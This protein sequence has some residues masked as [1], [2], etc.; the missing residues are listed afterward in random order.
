[1]KFELFDL[2]LFINVAEQS[3]L[4]KGAQRSCISLPAASAR[5]KHLEKTTRSTLF[6]RNSHGVELTSAGRLLLAHARRISIQV[7]NMTADLLEHSRAAQ[8]SIR[9]MATTV[10]MA[11][12]LP[13]RIGT[14]LNA[15]PNAVVDITER[16]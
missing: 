2:R 5:I 7:D 11:G 8:A 3:S 1:M 9:L 6:N 12:Q 15:N 4:T 13:A 16:R 14:F 10:A